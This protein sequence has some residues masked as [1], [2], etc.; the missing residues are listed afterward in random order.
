MNG[1]VAAAAVEPPSGVC[2]CA[3]LGERWSRKPP[4]TLPAATAARPSARAAPDGGPVARP[5]QL[6]SSST[7]CTSCKRQ[8]SGAHTARR[9]AQ[10]GQPGR[11]R[12]ELPA[13]L[14]RESVA[15]WL[16]TSGAEG[17]MPARLCPGRAMEVTAP[18]SQPEGVA[19]RGGSM[20]VW[21]LP[22]EQDMCALQAPETSAEV[23]Q[24]AQPHSTEG[25][26]TQTPLQ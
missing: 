13:R 12:S 22:P 23:G 4:G 11:T 20:P 15:S 5:S 1:A 16:Q 25:A 8:R 17:S 24:S 19:G 2:S 7:H 3:L 14:R 6:S 18:C 26:M 21:C 9:A 10:A